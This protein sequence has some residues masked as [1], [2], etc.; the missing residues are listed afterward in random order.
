MGASVVVTEVDPLRALEAA[1]DGFRVLPMREAAR[2]SDFVVTATGDRNV[3]GAAAFEVMKG[4][5]VLANAGH[6]D[7]EID[8]PAL[9]AITVATARPRAH[10]EEHRLRD[11]R[12]LR[13]L[14][15]GRLVNL[16]AAEGHPP[17]VMDMR[18]ANQALCAEYLV[19]NRGHLE[20]EVHEVP[21]AI[22][23]EVARQKLGAF[24]IEIDELT[25]EQRAYLTSWR[26][27]TS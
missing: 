9:R 19:A 25:P 2:I 18:F 12:T 22:D 5:C 23:R 13:V 27:G 24:G 16:A 21:L 26:E 20:P 7:V 1:M 4:G 11:G 15:E 10:V 17:T 8:L 14:A 6:F 3:V